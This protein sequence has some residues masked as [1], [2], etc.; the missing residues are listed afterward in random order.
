MQQFPLVEQ[1][2]TFFLVT[3]NGIDIGIFSAFQI[4]EAFSDDMDSFF[5][6]NQDFSL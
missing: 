2:V 4:R 3:C 6:F 5:E 1:D